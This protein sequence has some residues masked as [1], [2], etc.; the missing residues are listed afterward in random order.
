M[1]SRRRFLQ[2]SLTTAGALAMGPAY[3]RGALAQTPT[4]P[5]PGPYGPLGAPDPITGLRVPEGFSSRVV[6]AALQP[7]QGTGYLWPLFPDGKATYALPDGGY[8]LVVN[9]EVPGGLGGASSITFDASGRI[10]GARRILAGTSVNCSGGPT[11]WGTWLSGEE[12]DDPG[13]LIWECDPLGAKDAVPRPAM[14][15]FKHEAAC[16]DPVG[17]RA[18]L[19]EDLSDG[20]FYRFT[21][22][23]WPDLSAGV[24]EIACPGEG[25]VVRWER[26]PDPSSA[27]APARKQVADRLVFRRGEGIFFDSGTVYL[28]TT[29][30]DRIWAYDTASERLEVLYDGKATPDAPLHRVDNVTTHPP[31]GDLFVCEDADDLQI[32]LITADREVAPVVQFTGIAAG[33]PSELQTEVAGIAFDPS[34]RRLYFSSQRALGAGI[35]YEVSGPFRSLEPRRPPTVSAR[36]A[37]LA[38]R[39]KPAAR[40]ATVRRDGLLVSFD[41]PQAGRYRVALRA[42]GVTVAR[43]VRTVSRA[44]TFRVRL[45]APRHTRADLARLR[46]RSIT[47]ALEAAGPGALRTTR[48]LRLTRGG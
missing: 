35:T 47:A 6:A 12:V 21:P 18:Y 31:S 40:L 25:D 46:G 38:L 30:D 13:G 22:E 37:P 42:G 33:L 32:C 17:R 36:V 26:V 19:S 11:P 23:A 34:G 16:V 14:G 15:R 28:A 2:T 45:R 29:S 41:A 48:P 20:G 7:V 1:L 44:G 4:T 8:V 9:S 27:T 39:A 10:T 24:L 43:G 3:W 5:G